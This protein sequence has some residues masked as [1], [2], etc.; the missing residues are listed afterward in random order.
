MTP[1]STHNLPQTP[2]DALQA[3]IGSLDALRNGRALYV[4]NAGSDTITSFAVG[5]DGRLNPLGSVGGVPDGANGLAA[6]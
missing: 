5:K 6:N 4:L 1:P 2:L 3:V